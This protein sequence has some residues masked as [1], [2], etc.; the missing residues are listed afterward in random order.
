MEDIIVDGVSYL[1]EQPAQCDLLKVG[2]RFLGHLRCKINDA[3]TPGLH[4]SLKHQS[5]SYYVV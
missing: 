4:N 5:V 3:M 2:L 1:G